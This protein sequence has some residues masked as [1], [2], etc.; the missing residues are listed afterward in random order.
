MSTFRWK[1]SSKKNTGKPAYRCQRN[2]KCRFPLKSVD[3][4][5]SFSSSAPAA[6]YFLLSLESGL[7]KLRRKTTPPLPQDQKFIVPTIYRE[8]YSKENFL[9]YDKRKSAYGGRLMIFA[10]DDQL[11]VLYDSI[12]L[13][14]DGTFKV[15]P[16]LFEQL[17]VIH[18]MRDGEGI[19]FLANKLTH[20]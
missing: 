12:I 17:Y 18:G 4:N 2:E 9:I 5:N 3:E 1:L 11:N 6:V 13:F 20:E 15:A 16:T 7:H 14:A 8:T 10:S 19:L